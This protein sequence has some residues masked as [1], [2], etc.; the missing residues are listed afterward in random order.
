LSARPGCI[1]DL[2]EGAIDVVGDVHGERRALEQLLKRLGYDDR[3][4]HPERRRLVFVG[5]LVD[6]GPDSPGV[7]RTVKRL[8]DAGNAQC[9]A[10]NHELN[11][12]RDEAHRHRPGEGWWYGRRDADYDSEPVSLDEKARDFMPFLRALPAALERDDLRVV[13]ACWH[14][15]AIDRM[16]AHG[17]VIEAFDREHTTLAPT[18]DALRTRARAAFAR[19]GVTQ[20]AIRSPEPKLPFIP[21]LADHDTANQVGNAVKVVTSGMEQPAPDSFYASGKWRMVE[22]VKWWEDYADKP[23]VVGH[24]WRRYDALQIPPEE[25]SAADVFGPHPPNAWLGRAGRVM[26]IDFS[27][28][29][30]FRERREGRVR[31]RSQFCLAAL[32]VPEWQLVFDDDRPGMVAEPG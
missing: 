20:A 32:R 12:L 30:R 6:R 5:D 2:F 8:V 25:K 10:G 24:Y 18:L 11:A 14:D 9:I 29:M 19:E 21:E 1:D 22:R 17:S 3:G 13:H 28:G 27:V 26:C 23:V 7:L 31:E 16:R 15:P 4:R